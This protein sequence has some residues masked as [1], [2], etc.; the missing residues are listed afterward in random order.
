MIPAARTLYAPGSQS[1]GQ[2]PVGALKFDLLLNTRL[3]APDLLD[4]YKTD[5][6][7]WPSGL[8]RHGSGMAMAWTYVLHS[9]APP[10]GL[11]FKP[12]PK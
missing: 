4:W 9:K 6:W 2:N 3:P 7:V 1:S 11:L 5:E 12:T 10:S 8:A